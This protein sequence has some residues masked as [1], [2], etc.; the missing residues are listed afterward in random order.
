MGPARAEAEGAVE[1]K[2]RNQ[3]EQLAKDLSGVS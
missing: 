1:D 2:V 3:R